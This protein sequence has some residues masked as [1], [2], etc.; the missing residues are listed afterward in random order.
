MTVIAVT[1]LVYIGIF[2]GL[3]YALH[4]VMGNRR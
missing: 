4:V 2:I 1:Y 3:C